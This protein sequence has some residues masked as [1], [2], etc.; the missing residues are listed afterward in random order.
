MVDQHDR[1]VGL[2]PLKRLL[3]T[4][5]FKAVKEIY[6]P[7]FISVRADEDAE[8]AAKLMEK[9]DLVVLPV[10][11]ARGRLLGRITIDDV[12]DVIREEET[13]DEQRMAGM[14]ALEDSLQKWASA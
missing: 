1:R 13:E 7:D 4:S 5:L 9:Y 12:V 2:V 11:D 14:E 8:V 3:T 6:E 10:V